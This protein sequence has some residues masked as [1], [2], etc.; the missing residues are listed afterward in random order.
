[1]RARL[2][3]GDLLAPPPVRGRIEAGTRVYAV[4][5]IH[6]RADLLADLFDQMAADYR[7]ARPDLARI[8]YLGDYVDR[9]PDSRRVIDML[10]DGAPFPHIATWLKGNHEHH[11]L[12]FLDD[13][14]ESRVWFERGGMATLLSYGVRIPFGLP[15]HRRIEHFREELSRTLPRDHLI[16]LRDLVLAETVGDYF[17]VHA[18]V[19][20]RFPVDQQ[21]ADDMLNIRA[22]FVDWDEPLDK[23][24][25]HGHTVTKAP[26]FRAW[27][28][29]IDTGAFQSGCLTC[30]VL[31]D[32]TQR[33]LSTAGPRR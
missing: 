6:G 5:D 27:R 19:N 12:T 3:E 13:P 20:P 8:I 16:F 26:V 30:L 24:V 4:G 14:S 10:I 32:E 23:I 29:G 2:Y 21:T 22:P 31:E 15:A 25:V 11:L 1:L 18:G 7:K 17:F 9:G 28:I 33:I